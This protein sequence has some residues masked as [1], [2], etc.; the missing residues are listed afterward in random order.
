MQQCMVPFARGKQLVPS[1]YSI[2][3]DGWTAALARSLAGLRTQ[4][5]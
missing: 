3:R 1:A 2:A 4:L 5:A